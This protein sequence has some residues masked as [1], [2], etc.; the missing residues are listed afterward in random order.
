MTS[1]NSALADGMAE[2]TLA[3]TSDSFAYRFQRLP[4]SGAACRNEGLV[5]PRRGGG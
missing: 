5:I 2:A 4:I 3:I 1:H